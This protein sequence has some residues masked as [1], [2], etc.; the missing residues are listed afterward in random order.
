MVTLSCRD[1]GLEACEFV[2]EADSER[3]V[4]N[5]MF[6]HIRDEHPELIAGITDDQ[7]RDLLHRMHLAVKPKLAA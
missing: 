1:L 5:V 3:H 2:A 4:E 6:D 7:Q